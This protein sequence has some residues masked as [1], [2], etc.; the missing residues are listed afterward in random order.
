M[1]D[2]T[3]IP[4]TDVLVV[5]DEPLVRYGLA[6]VLETEPDIRVAAQCGSGQEALETVRS[7]RVNVV[8]LDIRMEGM[9]GLRTLAEMRRIGAGLPCLM[10][11]TFGEDA[12]V[13]EAIRLGADGFVLKSGDPRELI[14]A[15]RAVATGG[16]H[17][18]PSVSRKLL[19]SRISTRFI[20]HSEAR[21]RS[22]R[23]TEREG[24][25]LALIGDGLSNQEIADRL[26][27]SEGTVKTHVTSILRTTGARNRVEVALIAAHVADG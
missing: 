26:F 16:A 13:A 12:Y 24:E 3:R 5:D 27:L 11:T 15:V 21:E 20:Q 18:S 10:V 19:N 1:T 6:G 22:L 2:D 4:S 25:V 9:D 8:L 14:L 7:R 17:F 23:L